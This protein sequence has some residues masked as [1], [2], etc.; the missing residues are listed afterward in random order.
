MHGGDLSSSW[1]TDWWDQVG[2][3]GGR[4]LLPVH[5]DSVT[6]RGGGGGGVRGGSMQSMVSQLFYCVHMG[7]I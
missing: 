7:Y 1:S 3:I 4:V 5:W 2:V 6:G